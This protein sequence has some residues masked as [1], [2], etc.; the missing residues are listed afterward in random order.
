VP[1][2]HHRSAQPHVI[3]LTMVKNEQD[4]IE[5]ML[6]HN[7]ALFDA[8][9]VLDNGSVDATRTIAVAL[10]REL[11][12]VVV[13]D[14]ARFGYTQGERMTRLL[15]AAQSAYFADFVLFLDADEFIGTTSRTALH[16]ELARI[17]PNGFGAIAW[18]TFVLTAGIKI[19]D[20][21]RD[22]EHRLVTEA[23]PVFKTVLR[24]DGAFRP[25]LVVGRGSH[26]VTCQGTPLPG[27][28]LPDLP[29]WHFPIRSPAQLTAKALVGWL[30]CLAANP[31]AAETAES[32]HWR[33]MYQRIVDGSGFNGADLRTLSLHYADP[34]FV[35]GRPPPPD[36]PVVHDPAPI[37]TERRYSTGAFLDPLI[38]LARSWEQALRAHDPL[39][40]PEEAAGTV[41][42][43][44]PFRFLVDKYQP[45]SVLDIGCGI[46]L[47]LELF[48]RLGVADIAG[49]GM[50]PRE[51]LA[52]R[53]GGYVTHDPVAAFTFG[54]QY[55]VVLC[56][57]TVSTLSPNDALTLI[58]NAVR[59]A[60]TMI[61][62]S[63]DDPSAEALEAWLTRWR[64]QG[65]SPD[66]P[67]TQALRC[68]S[69]WASLRRG[70]VLL[71]RTEAPDA[72]GETA[73]LL[74]IA[75]RPFRTPPL[76]PGV[77]E[78]PLLD[79]AEGSWLGYTG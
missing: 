61:V 2:T 77:H 71:R 24:L 26:A 27:I 62:F 75:R 9:I 53:Q 48:A 37:H 79:A 16:A 23:L 17:P 14:S 45:A 73:S 47:D 40:A 66:L 56:L 15:H 64:G 72:S 63:L 78:E 50:L 25:D 42:D 44:P 54:R 5:P 41:I 36:P 68:L 31:R 11:G 38:L 34:G 30:A 6:R 52:L 13:T 49:V 70:L 59:H 10:A 4:I 8:L 39:F 67:E 1:D 19:A 29:L 3:G 69:S 60:E 76:A 20:P 74:A 32:Y 35:L 46:G 58:G 18:R 28:L 7:A 12:N 51:A 22:L 43:I 57:N 55:A 65:W 21:P 33:G